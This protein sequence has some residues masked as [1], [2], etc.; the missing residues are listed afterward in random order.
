MSQSTQKSECFNRHSLRRTLYWPHRLLTLLLCLSGSY[1]CNVKTR[2]C[3]ANGPGAKQGEFSQS[4]PLVFN[5][6]HCLTFFFF[7]SALISCAA[8]INNCNII[9][10][11]SLALFVS[12][13]KSKPGGSS[14]KCFNF[15]WCLS[16]SHLSSP[17]IS[18]SDRKSDSSRL[19]L[20]SV[21]RIKRASH[22]LNAMVD[23]QEN[24]LRSHHPWKSSPFCVSP[25]SYLSWHRFAP[26]LF[27]RLL[28]T[29]HTSSPHIL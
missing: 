26:L 2:F 27:F 16:S 13:F 21:Y 4:F 10:L 28:F 1:K 23:S 9:A 17:P 11:G 22:R 14:T 24:G 18:S 6:R 7:S 12:V 25:Y 29:S 15:H 3:K 19:Q 8:F 20:R 5:R